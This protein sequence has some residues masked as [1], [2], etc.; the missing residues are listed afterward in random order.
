[1]NLITSIKTCFGKY[2]IFEEKA[3]KSEFWWFFLIVFVVLLG[4]GASWGNFRFRAN[5]IIDDFIPTVVFAF[6]S[7]LPLIAVGVRRLHDI[8]GSGG[9]N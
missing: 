1:M 7:F 9:E 8:N 5:F 4:E 2:A 3:S 6:M